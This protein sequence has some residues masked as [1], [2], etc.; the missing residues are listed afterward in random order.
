M[1][2]LRLN[3]DASEA[4]RTLSDLLHRCE[5]FFGQLRK[6]IFE[7]NTVFRVIFGLETFTA[8]RSITS[9]YKPWES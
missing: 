2:Y 3:A 1:D 5:E 7:R 6:I 8:I 9:F 4:F